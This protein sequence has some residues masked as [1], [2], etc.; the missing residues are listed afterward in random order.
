MHSSLVCEIFPKVDHF[1]FMSTG[2]ASLVVV[3]KYLT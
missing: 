1:K 2:P 3:N